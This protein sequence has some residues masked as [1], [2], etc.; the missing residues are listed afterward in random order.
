MNAYGYAIEEASELGGYTITLPHAVLAP[1]TR[2]AP[3][4]VYAIPF[5]GGVC[6]VNTGHPTHY[7]ALCAA[8]REIGQSPERVV[9]A[10]ATSWSLDALGN[11]LRFPRA[12][13]FIYSPDMITPRRYDQW[14][15]SQRRQREQ[16]LHW[17]IGQQPSS[18]EGATDWSE[19]LDQ[20]FAPVS[21]DLPFVPMSDGHHVALGTH[22]FEVV[23]TPG[24][25]PGHMCLV[26]RDRGLMMSGDLPIDGLPD[27]LQSVQDLLAS[28]ERAIEI[29]PDRVYPAHHRPSDHGLSMLRRGG[30]FISNFLSNVP[31]ILGDTP[32]LLQFSER[33]LGYQPRDLARFA[34]T[35]QVLHTLLE[36]M[37][38]ARVIDA[39]G[40]GLDER[41]YGSPAAS[42]LMR[43][44]DQQ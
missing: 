14:I 9:R 25:D 22:R 36:E 37:A 18:D 5:E 33:D 15:E 21:S 20:A 3:A 8:L 34:A 31:S 44:R 16:I 32:T 7:R 38:R 4:N 24:V 11:A 41:R 17:L 12:D 42:R 26:D 10:V 43:I 2:A 6:L 35:T 19:Y 23:A 29:A 13:V 39:H 28:I 1:L 40:E 30:R 27:S